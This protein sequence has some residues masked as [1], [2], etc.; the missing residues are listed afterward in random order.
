MDVCPAPAMTFTV[1]DRCIYCG[2]CWHNWERQLESVAKLRDL[3]VRRV[4]PGHGGR[5]RFDAGEWAPQ[6]DGVLSYWGASGAAADM[7]RPSN[8]EAISSAAICSK[9]SGT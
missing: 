5:R 4:L 8:S 6:I 3:D 7:Q 1:N 2:T 9:S